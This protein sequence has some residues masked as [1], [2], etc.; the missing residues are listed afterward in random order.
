MLG[1]VG[2]R[3]GREPVGA[4]IAVAASLAPDAWYAQVYLFPTLSLGR[5]TV[6]GTAV[7]YEPL[8]AG[9]VRQFYLNPLTATVPVGRHV[10]AG[11]S[12]V[13]AVQAGAPANNMAGPTLRLRLGGKRTVALAVLTD[14]P[15]EH[16]LR[17]HVGVRF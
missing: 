7:W 2:R 15:D 9:G 6:S 10:E 1:G 14:G 12:D 5:M 17:L 11:V 4:I 3:V 8:E 16:E 13:L